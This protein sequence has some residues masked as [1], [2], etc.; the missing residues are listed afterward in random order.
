MSK[1]LEIDPHNQQALALRGKL[2]SVK[3]A[4]EADDLVSEAP[5]LVKKDTKK[6]VSNLPN[7][8]SLSNQHSRKSSTVTKNIL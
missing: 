1:C 7:E 4:S 3:V 2:K 6:I 5:S 8:K